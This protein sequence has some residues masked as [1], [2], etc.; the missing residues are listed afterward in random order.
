MNKSVV[1]SVRILAACGMLTAALA[2]AAAPAAKVQRLALERP[3][4]DAPQVRQPR[5][6]SPQQ[7]AATKPAQIAATDVLEDQKILASDGTEL[8]RFG[9]ATA[10]AGDVAMVGTNDTHS[11]QSAVYVFTR[12]NGTWTQTQKLQAA[13]GVVG[14]NARFGGAI[15]IDG[16]TAIIGADGATIGANAEQGAAYV[17]R[18]TGGTWAQVAKIVVADGT[19]QDHFGNSVALSSRG[20]L[21]GAYAAKVND[22]RRGAVYLFNES[23][24]AWTQ[25]QKLRSPD[26]RPSDGFGW[27]VAFSDDSIIVSAQLANADFPGALYFF[28]SVDGAWVQRQKLLGETYSTMG[29]AIAARGKRLVVGAPSWGEG[30][31][32]YVYAE[33]NGSWV[34]TH[35]LQSPEGELFT[36][37]G[38]SVGLADSALVIGATASSVNG[39]SWAG[40]G[41]VFTE[42]NNEWNFAQKLI[43]SDAGANDSIG[44][45]TAVYGTTALL[46]SA[47]ASPGGSFLQ[48]AG[49]FYSIE[50]GVSEASAVIAP[51][52]LELSVPAGTTQ[53]TSLGIGNVG[54]VALD[55]QLSEGDCREGGDVPWLSLG[56]SAGS[57]ASGALDRVSV[58]AATAALS[59]GVYTATLCVRTNDPA[60]AAVPVDVRL[61]VTAPPVPA[62]SIALAQ[63][64]L[65]FNVA[66][67]GTLTQ[68]LTIA[69]AG[70]SALQFSLFEGAPAGAGTSLV[71]PT[72]FAAGRISQ[73]SRDEPRDDG[74]SCSIG[75]EMRTLANSWWR[76]FYFNEHP[77]VGASVVITGVTVASASNGPAGMP[78]TINLYALP[79][80]TAMDTIPRSALVSIGSASGVIDSGLIAVT[81]PVSGRIADTAAYDLV[82]EYHTPGNEY[83]GGIFYPGGNNSAS[84]THS[85]FY[86]APECDVDE[87][88]TLVNMGYPEFHLSMSVD[89]TDV[90]PPGCEASGALAWLSETPASGTVAPGANGVVD[91]TANAA[92]LTLGD[93]SG[94][95]CLASN[96]PQHPLLAVPVTMTVTDGPGD[97]LFCNGFE[98]GESG[99]C[100]RR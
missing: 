55:Y 16:D 9:Q 59:Q 58:S 10:M 63:S 75:G 29:Y 54:R 65:S 79:H 85:S 18:N 53:A 90:P 34:R 87:P 4:S 68:P 13:D 48:G 77:Q 19:A 80:A 69:N 84:E 67:D 12:S 17:F 51:E 60:R 40:S 61:T 52:A 78:I 24:S 83:G 88:V 44:S 41:Y 49:Y 42:G 20:A 36:N 3:S 70:G 92:G 64:S 30:G 15:A 89:V 39:A 37:F 72:V 66:A 14:D 25:T 86:S 45:T 99:V 8:Q 27:Q 35:M 38:Y 76:R 73:M 6:A 21:V 82:V 71:P 7:G 33:L 23:G 43:A 97:G 1:E 95:L 32:A 46:A 81:I 94:N 2:A 91:V 93:Y 11:G 5:Q 56:A 98:Q 22:A 96:D 50:R 57:V 28:K 26:G 47:V 100:G 62:P 31:A 74:I